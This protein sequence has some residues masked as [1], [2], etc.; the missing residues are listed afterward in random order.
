M[1]AHAHP[2]TPTLT[3]NSKST[4][5][6]HDCAHTSTHNTHHTPQGWAL[7]GRSNMMRK[8]LSSKP[9]QDAPVCYSWVPCTLLSWCTVKPRWP[10]V[11]QTD[12]CRLY[13]DN[14]QANS[15]KTT[16][17]DK[18]VQGKGDNSRHGSS[19]TAGANGNRH[20]KTLG[21]EYYLMLET[22]QKL[23]AGCM[24]LAVARRQADCR[25]VTIGRQGQ[26]HAAPEAIY[27]AALRTLSGLQSGGVCTASLSVQA[28][29]KLQNKQTSKTQ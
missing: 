27:C 22:L 7:K 10:P 6:A 26:Q 8:P 18:N 21:S 16:S 11:L 13:K 28:T 17:L 25:A 15:R 19:A 24:S 5:A 23:C 20:A 2:H 9:C 14:K 3:A 1:R 29:A 4:L 12:I